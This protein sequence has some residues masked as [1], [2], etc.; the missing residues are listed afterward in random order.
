VLN[1]EIGRLFTGL[2][3][4]LWAA[5]TIWVL[6]IALEP[7]VRRFWPT[8]LIAWSRM[9]AG[10]LRDPLVGRDVLIGCLFAAGIQALGDAWVVLLGPAL[11]YTAQP[12][13]P[14]HLAELNGI[15]EVIAGYGRI[16]FSALL[17]ALWLTFGLVILKL[18]FR[19]VWV[20]SGVALV[21][22]ILVTT[23]GQSATIP[24]WVTL[25]LSIVSIG[26]ILLLM[27]RFGL[28]AT[29]VFF[30][31]NFMVGQGALTLQPG[32]WFFATSTW[33]LT[34]AAAIAAYGFYASRGG[35]PLLGRRLLD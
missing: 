28:L 13:V 21:F 19:R 26:L 6:Y 9:T 11:G 24:W 7:Y 2:G 25:P 5:S 14:S 3:D 15:R 12:S 35:E 29:S 27:L 1:T 18:I 17:N 8:T 4:A 34:A 23:A 31:V 22:F 10:Q 33:T 32:R 20:T 30:F 16:L